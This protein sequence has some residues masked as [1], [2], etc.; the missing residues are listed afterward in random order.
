MATPT[1]VTVSWQFGGA[2]IGREVARRLDYRYAAR[3]IF[4]EAAKRL[5][6]RRSP[7]DGGTRPV[8]RSGSGDVLHGQRRTAFRAGAD[9][10]GDLWQGGMIGSAS[11]RFAGSPPTPGEMRRLS[12]GLVR[13]CDS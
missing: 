3:E 2:R 10:N 7:V 4:A 8:V 9:C 6:A 1:V 12:A 11:Y 5:E 13:L